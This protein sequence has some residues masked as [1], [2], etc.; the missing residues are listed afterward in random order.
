VSS[1]PLPVIK[2]GGEP[3]VWPDGSPVRVER[4]AAL[5]RCCHCLRRVYAT[6]RTGRYALSDRADGT[7]IYGSGSECPRNAAGHE[8]L[9]WT[10]MICGEERPDSLINVQHRPVSGQEAAFPE[11]RWNVRYCSDR[12]ACR[13]AAEQAR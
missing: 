1:E 3:W 12:V 11:T 10:C 4:R 6:G 8:L 9:T 7:D 13:A 5:L 2:G